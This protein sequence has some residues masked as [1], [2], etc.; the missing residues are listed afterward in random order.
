MN[1][2]A[3]ARSAARSRQSR[4]IRFEARVVVCR[5]LRPSHRGR[6]TAASRRCSIESRS[7]A[8][9]PARSPGSGGGDAG[10]DATGV[11]RRRSRRLGAERRRSHRRRELAGAAEAIGDAVAVGASTKRRHHVDDL[12]VA[13]IG[14]E[15]ALVP[16]RAPRRGRLPGRAMSPRWRR[17]IRFSGSSA[18]AVSKTVRGFVVAAPPRTAPA[19]RRCARSCGRAAAAGYSS[20]MNIACSRS[21]A[22]RI[23]VRQRREVPAGIL[24]ELLFQL[25]D[26]GGTGH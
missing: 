8:P 14:L 11:R 9:L 5:D 13:R 4:R 10:A 17:A 19:R 2:G 12:L 18:S 26:S 3:R 20:Q 25:V 16:A 7:E 1:V 24:V 6:A 23:L 22:L 15:H 21:P